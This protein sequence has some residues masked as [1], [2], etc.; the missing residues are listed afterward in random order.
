MIYMAIFPGQADSQ[1]NQEFLRAAPNSLLQ[2]LP[3]AAEFAS[4]IKLIN[5][6]EA[7]GGLTACVAADPISRQAVGYLN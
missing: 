1:F 3:D 5:V 4:L 6:F 2:V 7:T